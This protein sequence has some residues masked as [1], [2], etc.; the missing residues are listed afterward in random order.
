MAS[1]NTRTKQIIGDI[2]RGTCGGIAL[3]LVGLTAALSEPL[4][5]LFRAP[6]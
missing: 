6:V 4:L 2:F 1:E 3:T 5:S